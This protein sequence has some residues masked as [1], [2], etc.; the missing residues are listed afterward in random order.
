MRVSKTSFLDLLREKQVQQLATLYTAMV[1]NILLGFGISILNTRFLGPKSYGDLKFL[2]FL[3]TLVAT[4]LSFGMYVSLGRLLA[5]KSHADQKKQLISGGLVITLLISILMILLLYLSS[6]FVDPIFNNGLGEIIRTFSPF[7]FVFPFQLCFEN[8]MQGDNRIFE[9]SFL[10]LA[11][12]FLYL[13]V[14]FAVQSFYGLTLVA[15]LSIQVAMIAMTMLVLTIL[16]KPEF[17]GFT[18]GVSTILN[19]N[20][21]YGIHVYVGSLSNVGVSQ[22]CVILLGYFIDTTAVGFFSLAV[23]VASPLIL[24][25]NSVGTTYFKSFA[26]S[27]AIS[28]KVSLLTSALSLLSLGIFLLFIDDIILIFYSD[29]YQPVIWLASVIAIGCVMHGFGDFLNRFLGAHGKGKDL[30]NSAFWVGIVN[31]T[32]FLFLVPQYGVNGAAVTALLT[33]LIYFLLMYYHYKLHVRFLTLAV[34]TD[35]SSA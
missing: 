31:V 5:Q 34:V 15:S 10:R 27:N 30:R 3:F 2:Q 6:F 1:L 12:S 24:I 25:P 28:R 4:V 9:L 7:L 14:A 22:L 17:A 13:T 23:T 16:L 18:Q 11:P 20:R 35:G 26:E 29:A 21:H 33:D 8:L 19:E 32:G